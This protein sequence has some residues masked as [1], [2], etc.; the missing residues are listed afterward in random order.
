MRFLESGTVQYAL[1]YPDL[2]ELTAANPF[3]QGHHGPNI[4]GR[5]GNPLK[6]VRKIR[7][8]AA[9]FLKHSTDV[10]F[11]ISHSL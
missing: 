9:S 11:L 5:F 2:R 7:P 4:Y 10:K 6:H 3:F 8:I 1:T